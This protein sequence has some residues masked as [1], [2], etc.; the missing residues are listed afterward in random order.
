M[1]GMETTREHIIWLLEGGHA[2]MGLE[3]AVADFPMAAINRRPEGVPYSPWHL[4]EHLRIA[5]WDILT[6]V[7]D[8]D[9]QSPRWPQGYWPAREAEAD[10]A[11]WLKTLEDFK[12]DHDR[13]LR[14]ARD[15][16]VDLNAPLPHAPDYT[17]LRELLLVA[18]HNA[19]HIGEFAILR[20]V[21]GTW[22]PGRSGAS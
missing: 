8:P 20:G 18:D 4:L 13:L 6:F 15:R 19:Y 5:Q 2:H 17:V 14:I 9:H 1:T 12:A 21:M 16:E 22:P 10:E 3:E 11:T 7:V